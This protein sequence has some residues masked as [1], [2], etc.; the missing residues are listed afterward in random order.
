MFQIFQRLI[1][2]TGGCLVIILATLVGIILYVV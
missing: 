1:D 2:G